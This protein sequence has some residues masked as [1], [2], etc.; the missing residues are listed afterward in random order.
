LLTQLSFFSLI[1]QFFADTIYLFAETSP[2]ILLTQRSLVAKNS[3]MR[4]DVILDTKPNPE[5]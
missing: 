3:N 4:H 5:D 1:C 2:D